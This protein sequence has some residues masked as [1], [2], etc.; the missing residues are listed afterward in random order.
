[1]RHLVPTPPATVIRILCI[2]SFLLSLACH[3]SAAGLRFYNLPQQDLHTIGLITAIEQDQQGFI[4][5]AGANGLARFDGY[6]VKI[7]QHKD[8]DPYSISTNNIT[9]M[10]LDKKSGYFWIATYWG[11]NRYDPRT[12]EFKHYFHDDKNAN[13]L[14]RNAILNVLLDTRENL[15]IAT[16]GSGLNKLNLKNSQISRFDSNNSAVLNGQINTIY[17][18]KK[19]M[20][21][22]GYLD[23]GASQ[24]RVMNS[25]KFELIAHYNLENK[26]LSHN[27]VIDFQ[28]DHL[29]RIWVATQNGLDRMDNNQQWAHY[30]ND[31]Q[32]TNSLW[33]RAIIDLHLDE[34]QRLW[35][36]DSTGRIYQVDHANN[37]FIRY[38]PNIEGTANNIFTDQ[39]GGIWLGISPS[40]V[41]RAHRYAS[42][43]KNYTDLTPG[44]GNNK[45]LEITAVDEDSL[46]NLWISTQLS[47]NYVSRS[48]GDVER[49]YLHDS[50]RPK[51]RRG[52]AT[53]GIQLIDDNTLWLGNSWHGL[54][55]LNVQ[56]QEF[57]HYLPSDDQENDLQT[58][59]IWSITQDSQK[60]LWI[61][62]HQGWLHKY[63]ADKNNFDAVQINT[64]YNANRLMVIYEDKNQG[65]WIGAD[66]GLYHSKSLDIKA[67][68]TR[69]DRHSK[70]PLAPNNDAIFSIL[71]DSRG[72]YWF[73]SNGGGLYHWNPLTEKFNTYLT[74]DGLAGNTVTGI[75]EADNGEIWLSTNKGLSRFDTHLRNFK[76]FTTQHGLPSNVFSLAANKRLSTG[77]LAFGSAAG[78]TVFNPKDI[79]QN[80]HAPNVVITQFS[81]FNRPIIPF[82]DNDFG[83]PPL[84][85]QQ[86]NYTSKITLES[87][88]S[89]FSFDFS[90]LNHDL[91]EDNQYAYK[92]DGFD[93]EW[94]FSGN[95]RQ[96][97]YTNLNPGQYNFRVKAANNEGLWNNEGTGI[98][99]EILPP[100]WKT[101][102]AYGL[103]FLLAT[104]VIAKAQ[105]S[106][107]RKRELAENQSRELEKKVTERTHE[108][109]DKNEELEAAYKAMEEQSLSDQLTGL[110]NRHFLYKTI[111]VELASATRYYTQTTE[112]D[113]RACA[114]ADLIFYIIDLDYF[115]D[116]NDEYGH[117]N[118]DIVLK[119]I[120]KAL[121]ECCRKSDTI[122]RW[123]GEEFL[124]VSRLSHRSSAHEAA[125]R[126]RQAVASTHIALNNGKVIQRTCSIGFASFPCDINNPTLLSMEQTLH[127]ADHCLYTVK[128]NGRNGWAGIVDGDIENASPKELTTNIPE[129]ITS[130]QL[131][132]VSSLKQ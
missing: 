51:W 46:G 104:G 37:E 82:E 72:H 55:S 61:G 124:I 96:A 28:E 87:H 15:W 26:A 80:T 121:K 1:M 85:T 69:Y 122:V 56:K 129:L 62:G 70:G 103:Y 102:W 114:S 35:I 98:R 97:T 14:S 127:I 33:S 29:G 117:N 95:R 41:A 32:A 54:N 60:Q 92:L 40:G 78:L 131:T 50:S 111:P 6:D 112:T 5:F 115:K 101:W 18:D 39:Q 24:F 99:I 13:S 81:L 91:P 44:K 123:G 16:Q 27:Y 42:A 106:Q 65:L 67:P 2:L 130:Q 64:D 110:K 100:W 66:N 118:G 120:A 119:Q 105:Y 75:L 107:Y 43:F 45:N 17:E 63:N 48:T 58:R 89:V 73:G 22:V 132:L 116:V 128:E 93:K 38:N 86:I 113:N 125:E 9:D 36:V 57:E 12:D 83:R 94:V 88:Q 31:K 25:G 49:S 52:S 77:E 21:W 79:Y 3:S 7:L 109:H 30:T 4:W 59:Q 23:A 74:K 76:N 11:L 126:I 47:L 34:Q 20:L 84:L 90:A 10:V 68:F 108:L 8:A 71:H 53:N 19:G